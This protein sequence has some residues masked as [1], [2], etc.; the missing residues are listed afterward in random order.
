[1]NTSLV[2]DDLDDLD[3]ARGILN[4]TVLSVPLWGLILGLWHLLTSAGGSP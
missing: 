1:M 4:A 3:G 2:S